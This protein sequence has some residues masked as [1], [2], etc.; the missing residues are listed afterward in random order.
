MPKEY[1]YKELLKRARDRLPKTVIEHERFQVPEVDVL[2]EGKTTVVRNFTELADAINREPA[3][4][5]E[6]EAPLGAFQFI[7]QGKE[8]AGGSDSFVI[9]DLL[10]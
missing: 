8:G 5:L 10:K 7:I 9:E 1:D 4:I 2:I 6:V 3:D